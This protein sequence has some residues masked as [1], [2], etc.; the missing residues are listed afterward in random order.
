[1]EEVATLTETAYGALFSQVRPRV[2]KTE[3]ENERAIVEAL[4]KA[5]ASPVLPADDA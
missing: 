2:I 4:A 5:A 3:A 1:M